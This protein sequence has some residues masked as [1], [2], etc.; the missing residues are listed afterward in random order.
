MHRVPF[1]PVMIMMMIHRVLFPRVMAM[2][3]VGCLCI[4]CSVFGV[5]CSVFLLVLGGLIGLRRRRLRKQ[6]QMICRN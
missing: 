4:R 5:G 3:R 6:R 2:R 1:L